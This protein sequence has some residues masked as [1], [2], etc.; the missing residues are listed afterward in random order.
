MHD[1]QCKF[2]M[3]PV[4][5]MSRRKLSIESSPRRGRPPGS[6]ESIRGKRVVTLM[7]ENDYERLRRIADQD[8]KSMSKLVHDIVLKFIQERT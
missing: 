2:Q 3:E 4:I 7:T 1:R 8:G 5:G 6:P